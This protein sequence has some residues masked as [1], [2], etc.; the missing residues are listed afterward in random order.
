[1]RRPGQPGQRRR[2]H[3]APADG[4]RGSV[5]GGSG[6][7]EE[8]RRGRR[9]RGRQQCAG[10][11][12]DR[13]RGTEERHQQRP[14]NLSGSSRVSRTPTRVGTRGPACGCVRPRRP[15]PPTLP[16]TTGCAVPAIG[17]RSRRP[18]SGSACRSSRGCPPGRGP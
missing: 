15:R 4:G 5:E 16:D 11:V 18:W 6:P 3:H 12:R 7:V 1:M 17:A 10:R 14:L 13:G 8:S 9:H 2:L